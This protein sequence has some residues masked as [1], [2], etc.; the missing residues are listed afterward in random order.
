MKVEMYLKKKTHYEIISV[1]NNYH[2]SVIS[3]SPID[4]ELSSIVFNGK[5]DDFMEFFKDKIFHKYDDGEFNIW[6][7]L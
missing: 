6:K 4:N 3:F 2:I 5:F 1:S 7:K